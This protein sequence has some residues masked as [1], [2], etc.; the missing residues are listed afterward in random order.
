MFAKI[1]N[2]ATRHRY[3]IVLT[4]IVLAVVI[5]V[6]APSIDDV[7]SS[8][9]ADFLPAHAPYQ[10][11]D[12]VYQEAFPDQYTLG[13]TYVV[14]DA[15]RVGD[16]HDETV[17]SFI[18]ELETWLNSDDAPANI[19][20]VIAPT[21]NPYAEKLTI[22]D[23][24]KLA[25]VSVDLSTGHIA[26]ETADT[27]DVID[28]WVSAHKPASIDAYQTGASP[29]VIDTDK[30]IRTSVDRT[31][32][33]TIVLVVLLLLLIYR[34]PVSPLIPLITVT[35]SYF[36][37]RGV[38]GWIGDNVMTITS[39]VKVL[40][41][42]IL[43]GAGTDYCLFMI[44]RFREEMADTTDTDAATRS[45]VHKVGETI[46][47][48]AG[49][50][51]VGFMAMALAEMGLFNTTGPALA[52]GIV[53]MLAAGLT[54]TPALLA[55][56]GAR[57][58]WPGHA[59]HRAP[60]RYFQKISQ[61]VS[62][63]P[64]ITVL[65]IVAL[66]APFSVYALTLRFNYD[67]VADM[68]S[69]RPA[70]EGFTK[71][72]EH[73][74]KGAVLPL[75]IAVTERDPETEAAEIVKLTNELA[76][77]DGVADVR[78]M[79]SPF[80]LGRDFDGLL[81]P[82]VQLRT[83]VAAVQS[84]QVAI[85]DPAQALA[86][87]GD[88]Q[89][90]LTLLVTR[91]PEIADDPALVTMQQVLAA[92]NSAQTVDGQLGLAASLVDQITPEAL[93][94]IDTAQLPALLS[95]AGGYL[96]LLAQNY[97]DIASDPNYTTLKDALGG[98]PLLLIAQKDNLK[99]ALEGLAAT[100][101]AMD[102]PTLPIADLAALAEPFMPQIQSLIAAHEDDL[103]AAVNGLADRLAQIPDAA[104]LPTE[105][106]GLFDALQP[107]FDLYLGDDGTAYRLEVILSGV[108]TSYEAMDTIND[109]RDMLKPY[110]GTGEAQVSG[111]PVMITD[112]RDTLSSDQIRAIGL[113]LAGIFLVLLL[114]LRSLIS[115][116]YLILSVLLSY[117]T[118]LGFTSLV[119]KV[120]FGV[121]ELTFWMP[122]FTFVFMVALGIDYNIF[123]VGRLK[124]E[125]AKNGLRD[126][127]HTAMMA[128]GPIIGSAGL[129]LAGTFAAMMAGEIK[130]LTEIGFAVAVG[131]LLESMI[132]VGL[133]V[134]ALTILAGKWAWWPGGVPGS[135]GKSPVP[136]R[137]LS[138]QTGD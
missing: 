35:L 1:G 92:A 11:A 96:D 91:Y 79:N 121:D 49:T 51:F 114:M 97:P 106:G 52:V 84:G 117:T 130:G 134:P 123:F 36:V 33:V 2:F 27:I 56:L 53:V 102:H 89:N 69:D 10:H 6:L 62:A 87:V 50:I 68:P 12:E 70:S 115:P 42:V 16:V 99:A 41:V 20:K 75:N 19:T 112:I 138:G 95:A 18:G 32:W 38:V 64:L 86:M 104:I 78:G 58:F 14:I 105:A 100:F 76:A 17:W 93:T 26:T 21:T 48:S 72:G 103:L 40:M 55:I 60:G 109:I 136:S 94:Q 46:T 4:W 107:V 67:A 3:A 98:N 22:A 28:Q 113:V 47:S 77:L 23:D 37:T 119:Y 30:S 90:Y 80:G 110:A 74:D 81:R 45:T 15:S 128:T 57:A 127:I 8:D 133:L 63:R 7:A 101:A 39:Y 5:T 73:M 61:I 85:S 66:M 34:S 122:F 132:V 43:Y 116:L 83:A 29:I 13:S 137:E 54:L 124:E 31:I 129:I 71:L 24:Q 125:V 120:F 111:N 65:V 59:Q 9:Q 118:T 25:I 126:G 131:V 88:V 108:P 82:D 44:S 135:A